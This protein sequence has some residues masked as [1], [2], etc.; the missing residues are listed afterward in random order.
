MLCFPQQDD[1]RLQRA[2]LAE[3]ICQVRF[4]P[5][6]RIANEQP[7]AFQERIR[8]RFPQLEIEQ[9]VAIQMIPLGIEP[10]S[11]ESLPRIL[12]FASLNG[13]TVV[14]LALNFYALSTTAYTHWAD[15]LDHLLFV[16]Q[17]VREVYDIPFATRVGLRYINHLTLENTSTRNLEELLD[18]LRPEL[19]V[20]LTV[21]CWDKPVEMVNQLLLSGEGEERLALRSGYKRDQE[22]G[23]TLDFDYF[24][25]GQIPLDRLADLGPRYH[26]MIYSAFRWCI[27]EDKLDVFSPVPVTEED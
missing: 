8:K 3:V 17:A 11:P 14:S 27:Q 21:D 9:G 16:N 20:L 4:S 15:F 12:R 19:T 5:I 18:I 6:L 24:V 10:P 7:S 26:D 13:H 22:P 2:P 1:V 23:L 25:E